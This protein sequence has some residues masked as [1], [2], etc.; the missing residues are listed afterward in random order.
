M[1]E[2]GRSPLLSVKQLAAMGYRAVLFPQTAFRAT[3]KT[4]E[5]CLRDL[6]KRGTQKSWLGKMQTR[7]AL[8]D[9]LGY[10]PAKPTWP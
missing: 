2:F 1:T 8:Y 6:K 7:Q 9:L 5:Q 3:M 10:D 4:A